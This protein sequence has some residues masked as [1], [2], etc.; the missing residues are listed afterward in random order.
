DFQRAFADGSTMRKRTLFRLCRDVDAGPHAD[1]DIAGYF[2]RNQRLAQRR[3]RHAKLLCQLTLSRQP[4]ASRKLALLDE[5]SHPVCNL[6][7]K[8]AWFRS[9]RKIAHSAPKS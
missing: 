1:F 6:L 3:P 8:P 7:I 2:E 9:C 5:V 4:A